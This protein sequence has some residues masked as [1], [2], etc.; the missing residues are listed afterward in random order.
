MEG[1]RAE[2]RPA[3]ISNL[4]HFSCRFL[5]SSSVRSCNHSKIINTGIITH[6]WEAGV[7]L[8]MVIHDIVCITIYGNRYMHHY[9][10]M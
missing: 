9:T 10:C 6:V 2:I 8:Y 3:S 7:L 4:I 5:T 1:W